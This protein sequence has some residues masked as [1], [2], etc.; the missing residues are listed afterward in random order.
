M[1]RRPGMARRRDAMITRANMSHTHSRC[2]SRAP[3]MRPRSY[4]ALAGR[5]P[6]ASASRSPRTLK[7]FHRAQRQPESGGIRTVEANKTLARLAVD[8]RDGGLLATES[9]DLGMEDRRRGAEASSGWTG[10]AAASR[11]KKI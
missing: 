7:I 1:E 5:S 2:T 10:T 11:E 3:P 6:G 9:L 8:H 4:V